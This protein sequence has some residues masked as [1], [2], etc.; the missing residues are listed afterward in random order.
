MYR[1][2]FSKR[3]ESSI[4]IPGSP[5]FSHPQ[6]IRGNFHLCNQITSSK[7][8]KVDD[9]IS[10]AQTKRIS[11]KD[12]AGTKGRPHSASVVPTH[13]ISFTDDLFHSRGS[14]RRE[15]NM[16]GNSQQRLSFS[17]YADHFNPSFQNKMPC[18]SG[19]SSAGVYCQQKPMG[20]SIFEHM[21]MNNQ[22]ANNT[23][24]VNLYDTRYLL[25]NDVSANRAVSTSSK[26]GTLSDRF[27]SM[28][29]VGNVQVNH[30]YAINNTTTRTTS[31]SDA[32][33]NL[34]RSGFYHSSYYQPPLIAVTATPAGTLQGDHYSNVGQT[35][36]PYAPSSMTSSSSV[37]KSE[38]LTDTRT[39]TV[40]SSRSPSS[41]YSFSGSTEP[42]LH[43]LH[44]DS[45]QQD[46][47]KF[48]KNR[49]FPK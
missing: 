13:T 14:D 36:G 43:A 27:R 17:M 30:N 34:L 37:V 25:K 22:W 28:P 33:S 38:P 3:M 29:H 5:T 8:K 15:I 41:L 18:S 16:G 47:A 44:A 46:S 10:F 4:A 40:N 19:I 39:T 32:S 20:K 49:T 11:T 48:S 42:P 23:N 6:F 31:T 26:V 2:G 21:M 1:W 35:A 9:V 7:G 45:Q 24:Q 12:G